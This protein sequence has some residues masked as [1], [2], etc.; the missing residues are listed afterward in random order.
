MNIKE[1][2][3]FICRLIKG[4]ITLSLVILP[5][6]L[7]GILILYPVC[8]LRGPKPLPVF[9]NWFDNADHYFGRDTS[10]YFA[11]RDSGPYEMYYWLAIRNPLNYFGYSVLGVT[12]DGT[13]SQELHTESD[14]YNI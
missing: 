6:E 12:L 5:L 14:S 7:V 4:L 2:F 10:V 8:R 11:G 1:A 13:E 3:K 9:L